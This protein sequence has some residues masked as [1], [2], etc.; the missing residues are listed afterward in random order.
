MLKKR[1]LALICIFACIM[2]NVSAVPIFSDIPE[3]SNEEKV[4]N[5]VKGLGL[6]NGYEDGSF[7]PREAV[8]RGEVAQIVCNIMGFEYDVTD[9]K[10]SWENEYLG[11][12]S[13][14]TELI[15][16]ETGESSWT[17]VPTN[18]W[19]YKA[20]RQAT[21]VGVMQGDGESSFRPED[22]VTYNEMIKVILSLGGYSEEAK[23]Y[24][25]YPDG[26]AKIAAET[27]F[28]TRKFRL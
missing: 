28:S 18:S 25:G 1:I 21:G 12:D 4:L 22:T 5:V 13:K 16:A 27:W 20:I 19:A 11:D 17:D 23:Y 24:G 8:K 6:M 15:V 9:E 10:I 2:T 14:D 7:Q 3:N 26:Y